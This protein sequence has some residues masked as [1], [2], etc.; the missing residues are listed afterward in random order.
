MLSN[1]NKRQLRHY[2]TLDRR[3]AASESAVQVDTPPYG[4]LSYWLD[5]QQYTQNRIIFSALVTDNHN[6][7]SVIYRLSVLRL[8]PYYTFT[9]PNIITVDMTPCPLLGNI[10]V[11]NSKLFTY[12]VPAAPFMWMYYPLEIDHITN[13]ITDLIITLAT[14]VVRLFKRSQSLTWDVTQNKYLEKSAYIPIGKIKKIKLMD[15]VFFSNLIGVP[16]SGARLTLLINEYRSNAFQSSLGNYHYIF[17]TS[18]A[19]LNTLPFTIG[20]LE[21][22]QYGGEYVNANMAEFTFDPPVDVKDTL[23]LTLGLMGVPI[24]LS[25]QLTLSRMSFYN[26]SPDWNSSFQVWIHGEF[27]YNYV[28]GKY[29][30]LPNGFYALVSITNFKTDSPKDSAAI[31]YASAL[32]GF[33][34]DIRQFTQRQFKNTQKP[35]PIGYSSPFGYLVSLNEIGGQ[36]YPPYP[37]RDLQGNILSCN[38]Q[39]SILNCKFEFEISS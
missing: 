5:H 39:M 20:H 22:N 35:D 12:N 30:T 2:I 27:I 9:A 28:N 1:F 29:P 33:K 36:E 26:P 19:T 32:C 23:T 15:F 31:A 21:G 3:Y 11:N 8:A 17:N 38:M 6:D 24:F 16:A 34:I 13:N 10:D 25:S 37:L 14:P 4:L 18:P 7:N